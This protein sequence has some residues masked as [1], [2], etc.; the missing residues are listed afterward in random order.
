MGCGALRCS[1]TT[2]ALVE[3]PN[4]SSP[5]RRISPAPQT[6]VQGV[7]V[8]TARHLQA[9][10]E[11]RGR[12]WNCLRLPQPRTDARGAFLLSPA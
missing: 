12:M 5:R 10:V 2:R 4:D 3:V 9:V 11:V 1:S 6:R 8:R 7:D